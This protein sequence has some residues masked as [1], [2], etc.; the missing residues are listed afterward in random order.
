MMM[1]LINTVKF[2]I[3]MLILASLTYLSYTGVIG[4]SFVL[5]MVAIV[6]CMIILKADILYV[7]SPALFIQMGTGLDHNKTQGTIIY[8]IV[9]LA[10][11]M[12]DI[13]R[14]RQINKL[15][16]LF[17]PLAIFVALSVLTVFNQV[18]YYLTIA[19][20]VEMLVA[21][22][23]YVYF[24]NTMTKDKLTFI[25]IA[26]Y[27]TYL[28]LVVTAEMIYNLLSSDQEIITI[29]RARSIDLGWA[30]LNLVIYFNLISLPLI[31]YLV[32]NSK[33]KIFYMLYAL[34]TMT[35]IFLTLSRS[36]IASVGLYI[37][38]LVPL[39]LYFEKNRLSLFI[40][41][42]IFL[43]L[44]A[45]AGIYLQQDMII[46]DY[47]D[48]L[49]SRDLTDFESRYDL[50]LVAIDLLKENPI[51]GSGGVYA[52]RAHLAHLGPINYHNTIAQASTL[53]IFG[54]INLLYLFVLKFKIILK[55]SDSFKWFA[56][57]MIVVTGL[58]NGMFQP[59]YFYTTYTALMLLVLAAI[60][61]N[62]DPS[63]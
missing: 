54:I 53:G 5:I 9:I 2:D 22:L 8:I 3:Y 56:L 37:L 58:I 20:F 4:S 13:Y 12:I 32:V 52:S 59:M 38:V 15:G 45:G 33:V 24:V 30:N 18:S 46:T 61:V 16:N 39:V 60:E 63:K 47:M 27:V 17:I 25:N 42:F 40:Q 26:K 55:N 19:G 49:L 1:K 34:G 41:G 50:I 44:V 57:L 14:N 28:S 35:G 43:V 36:S 23:L 10:L 29:I 48:S 11:V 31:G 7:A 21:L 62:N 6:L 51:F